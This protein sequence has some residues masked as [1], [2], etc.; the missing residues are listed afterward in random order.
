MSDQ[1]FCYYCRRYHPT[2]EVR[3]IQS[4][5]VKRWRCMKSL[6][7]RLSSVAERDA[8]GKSV[9]ESNRANKVWHDA[10]P[11]PLPVLEVLSAPPN[12][13]EGPA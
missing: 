13:F 11:L 6:A 4:K 7:P 3:L 1:V 8:F 10:R 2:V 5:G 9:S 12:Q